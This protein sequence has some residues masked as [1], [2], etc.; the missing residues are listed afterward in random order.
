VTPRFKPPRIIDPVVSSGFTLVQEPPPHPGT[1]WIPA[2][3]GPRWSW[4]G[5]PTDRARRPSG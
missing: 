2:C 1:P 5:R 4:L 3:P